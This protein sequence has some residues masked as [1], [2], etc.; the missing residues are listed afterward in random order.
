MNASGAEDVIAF[1]R[2]LDP[3]EALG[4]LV[5]MGKTFDALHAAGLIELDPTAYLILGCAVGLAGQIDERSDLTHGC[6]NPRGGLT[7]GLLLARI[8]A[9]RETGP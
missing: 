4:E 6:P 2:T 1:V 7:L 8:S 5:H 9:R 3:D